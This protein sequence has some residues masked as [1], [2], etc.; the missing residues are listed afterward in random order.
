MVQ[1]ITFT[2]I[3]ESL[4]RRNIPFEEVTF[5]D[6]AVSGRTSDTSVD[7]NYD[8]KNAIKTLII[9]TKGGFMAVILKGSDKIDQSK[10]K[11]I[12]G[13]WSVVDS[14]TLV[15][16]LGFIPG[17]ICPLVLDMPFL[18][19]EAALSLKVWSIGGGANDKGLNVEV[20][21][22]L[23]HLSNYQKVSIRIQ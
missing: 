9:S 23:R 3:K 5:N 12:V 2:T 10:L 8:P 19:D 17:T 22:S 18:V 14:N 6:E 11:Q 15:E 16:K 20:Q 1:K 4:T 7:K 21:E 13:K